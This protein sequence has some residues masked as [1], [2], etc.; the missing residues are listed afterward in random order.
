[1]T[2][3]EQDQS[4]GGTAGRMFKRIFGA[5][6]A[7]VGLVLV[8]V[9]GLCLLGSYLQGDDGTVGACLVLLA[10]GLVAFGAGIHVILYPDKWTGEGGGSG[11]G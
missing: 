2:D 9:G 8:I 7:G 10:F 11:G 5:V 6:F 3:P 4:Q 1:M